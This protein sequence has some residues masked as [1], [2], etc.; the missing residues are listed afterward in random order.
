MKKF[1]KKIILDN[2]FDL[3]CTINAQCFNLCEMIARNNYWVSWCYGC[4]TYNI[5]NDNI[6]AKIPLENPQYVT[7]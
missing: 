7:M 1:V 6:T 4:Y 2:I 5:E 3:N